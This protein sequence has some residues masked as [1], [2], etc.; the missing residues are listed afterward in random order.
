MKR[1]LAGLM[2]LFI[3]L[4]LTALPA[5]AR[6]GV[7]IDRDAEGI[8]YVKGPDDAPLKAVFEAVGYAVACDRL[9][10]AETF[11]RA[12]LG[13]LA[14]ILGPDQ[15]KTD[16]LVRIT[17]YSVAEL[18]AAFAN[19]DAESQEV[20]I[21]YCN[22]FNKRLGEI[23]ANPALLPLEFAKLRLMPA[24][25][26]P[27]HVLAWQA[28][29]L[30]KFDCEATSR[31]QL[32]NAVLM[33]KLRA[34]FPASAMA[35][36]H[37]L[38]WVNDP[39]ALTY[40]DPPKT[41]TARTAAP[42]PVTEF[43]TPNYDL[44]TAAGNIN[45]LYNGFFDGLKKAG[46]DV[47]MGSYAW[48][49]SGSKTATGN[50]MLYSG[51]QMGFSVPAI[52][53]E[54]SIEAGGL[55]VSGMQ[56]AGIPGI[57][58]GRTPHH[59]WSMQVGHAHTVD[60]YLEKPEDVTFDRF[61]TI[62]VKGAD[63]V[64]IPV[65]KSKHGPIINPVPYDPAHYEPSPDNPIVAW[66]YSHRIL[67]H[68]TIKAYLDL[69]RA[70][71]PAEFGEALTRAGLSQHFCYVDIDGNIGYWMSGREPV[72]PHGEYRFPQ[73][74]LPNLPPAEWD[75]NVFEPLPHV[76]NPEKGWVGGWNN[77]C[78]ID[79]PNSF[80]EITST[81]FFGPFHRAQVVADYL[82]THDHLTFE[83]VRDL[84]INI[85]AT[86]SLAKGGN[87][88]AFVKDYFSAV[89]NGYGNETAKQL[90]LRVAGF[91]GHMCDDWVH[92]TERSFA[93]FYTDA[94]IREV[95]RLTFADELD[96]GETTYTDQD[97]GVLFNVLL[98]AMA[99]DKS[100]VA[101]QYNWFQNLSDPNAP[102]TL[103]AI[104][105]T[106][107]FTALKHT[108][109][110]PPRGEIEFKHPGFK[111]T[112]YDPLHT[113]PFGCRS[114]YVQCVEYGTSGPVRIESMFPLGESGTITL[115]PTLTLPT[116]PSMPFPVF[117]PNFYSMAP[118]YD[119]FRPR[120]FPLFE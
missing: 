41:G 72:R 13:T 39:R 47:K 53:G 42:S 4:G 25:W 85:A 32:D 99:G 105:L 28:L 117:D 93:W 120:P 46:A 94:W 50:P 82:S 73:G 87:P 37:D 48:A 10:Q 11:R 74:F 76:L 49:I 81:Y 2:L 60:F 108:P 110:F 29:M 20:I 112:A 3:G 90:L 35:M 52:I 55:K 22:G 103:P 9:W 8:W 106:A 118:Y 61:E 66:K 107:Q 116:D 89:V 69:A 64:T 1:F 16:I 70:Q 7:T 33:Q 38:R 96:F 65:F 27:Y 26:E 17:G 58:I 57:V 68:G 23:A 56:I 102:Q 54:G 88:W 59:A 101:N 114:T 109:W 78:S 44:T 62:K 97:L 111:G 79:R 5:R 19:L 12:G 77:K 84:A 113:T 34:K 100:G 21:G 30:R 14:E 119:N 98:H 104:I 24:P 51:P 91:D 67:E 36:F 71:S 63:D 86:D 83:E 45:A 40:I 80:N 95:L 15:L 31:G 43:K 18:K 75:A 115:H 6:T 92:G